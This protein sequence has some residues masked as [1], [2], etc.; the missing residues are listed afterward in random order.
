MN[1]ESTLSNGDDLVK[2]PDTSTIPDTDLT[3]TTPIA[4]VDSDDG[5]T[6]VIVVQAPA[7]ESS[8]EKTGDATAVDGEEVSATGAQLTT[9]IDPHTEDSTGLPGV[10]KSVFG[11]YH[12]RTQ[13]ITETLVDGTVLT[14]TECVPGLAGLDWYWIS[15]VFMFGLILWSFF[16][17]LG[18][19]LKS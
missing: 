12:P 18:G 2:S 19:V 1:F 9:A 16:R 10:V 8:E 14:S 17:F 5:K 13:T 3:D 11:E 7:A 6:T 4:S 15:G